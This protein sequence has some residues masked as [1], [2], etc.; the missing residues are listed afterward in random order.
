MHGAGSPQAQKVVV[1]R[2]VNWP[3]RRKQAQK[4]TGTQKA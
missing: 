2:M 4:I 1:Q 3:E